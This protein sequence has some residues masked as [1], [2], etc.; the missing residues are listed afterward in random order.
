MT[1]NKT[2]STLTEGDIALVFPNQPHSYRTAEC[3]EIMLLFF[4]AAYP[5][6]YAADLTN[7]VPSHPVIQQERL[8]EAIYTNIHTLYKLYSGQ[9]DS[10]MQKAYI[11]II[12]GQLLP[13]MSLQQVDSIQDLNL[14]QK[15]LAYVDIHFLEPLTLDQVAKE[16]GISRFLVSRIFSDQLHISFRDYINSRRAALAQILLQSTDQPVTDIAYDSGFNS[17]RSFYRVF[18]KE[19]GITPNEFRISGQ[20]PPR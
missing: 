18:R 8:E 10:R 11:S 6:D 9:G 17:L 15:I 5:A 16:L 20:G 13:L 14:I 19:Y 1:V 3:S 12:L 2:E 4:E 7:F